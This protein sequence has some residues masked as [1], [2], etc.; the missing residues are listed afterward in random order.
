MTPKA[1]HMQSINASRELAQQ[2]NKEQEPP[3]KTNLHFQE[4]LNT[5]LVEDL[6]NPKDPIP[7]EE[8]HEET[9]QEPKQLQVQ[10]QLLAAPEWLRGKNEKV[11]CGRN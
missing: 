6:G 3:S 5:M 11:T 4:C 1:Q 2:R 10:N 9:M 8:F 7:N